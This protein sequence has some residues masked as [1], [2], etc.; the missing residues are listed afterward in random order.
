MFPLKNLVFENL[1][2][3]GIEF[4]IRISEFMSLFIK[5]DGEIFWSNR[6]FFA[7]DNLININFFNL[8]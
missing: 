5:L 1:F 7:R 8:L 2:E 4:E 6:F 3:N